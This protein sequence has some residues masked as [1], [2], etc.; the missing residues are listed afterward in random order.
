MPSALRAQSR[1]TV[2]HLAAN[3]KLKSKK[4]VRNAIPIPSNCRKRNAR[5]ADRIQ[6]EQHLL[7]NIVH[8]LEIIAGPDGGTGRQCPRRAVPAA[9]DNARSCVAA[10][11]QFLS[12]KIHTHASI[13]QVLVHNVEIVQPVRIEIEKSCPICELNI[14]R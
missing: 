14:S 6:P 10:Y 2:V 1:P 12:A 3:E 4:T 9:Q 11:S 5:C 8:R 13:K 7:V